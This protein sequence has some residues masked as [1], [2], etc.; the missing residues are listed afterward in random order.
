ML[1]GLNA[2]ASS[3]KLLIET[4]C[5]L[6]LANSLAVRTL[7]SIVIM[8]YRLPADDVF[9]VG[10]SGAAGAWTGAAAGACRLA[11][12][13]F[14][15]VGERRGGGLEVSLELQAGLVHGV[16]EGGEGRL[17]APEGLAL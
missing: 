10:R 16:V 9:V 2:G 6:V 7:K 12:L 3:Q 8:N 15:Q 4:L 13:G 11:P 17:E 14:A 5:K 1:P